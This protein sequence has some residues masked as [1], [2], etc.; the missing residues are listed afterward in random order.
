MGLYIHIYR[1]REKG[2]FRIQCVSPFYFL[3]QH[4]IC[5]PS[6]GIGFQFWQVHVRER[7]S[8]IFFKLLFASLCKLTKT[9]S[10]YLY[11][12]KTSAAL[13]F[14]YQIEKKKKNKKNESKRTVRC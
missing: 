7:Y 3:S 11:S 5:F 14:D 8:I 13:I 2:C 6:K 10:D 4:I 9:L 12:N 1:E